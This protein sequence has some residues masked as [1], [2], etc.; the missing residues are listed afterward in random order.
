M[1]QVGV[2]ASCGHFAIDNMFERLQNDHDNAKNLADELN[3]IKEIDIDL[4]KIYT[5]LIFFHLNASKITD[6]SFIKELLNYKIKIDYKGN[7]RFRMVTHCNFN[8]KNVS[9][10]TTAIK[11]IL[12]K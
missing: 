6:E 7:H 12:T 1:R 11:K 4:Q 8:E 5:N 10:V 3:N 2:L 9:K